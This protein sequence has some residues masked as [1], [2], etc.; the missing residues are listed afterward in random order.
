MMG[1]GRILVACMF[2]SAIPVGAVAAPQ[3]LK[4]SPDQ[5]VK[6]CAKRVVPPARPA[7]VCTENIQVSGGAP[8]PRYTFEVREGTTLPR[9]L[10]LI[11]ATGVVTATNKNPPLP[12][13]GTKLLRITVSDGVRSA[14]GSVTLQ[15]DTAADCSCPALSAGF[16]NP[17]NARGNQ[18][19][20]FALPVSGPP[21]SETVSPAYTW[22]INC[23]GLPSSICSLP[24]GMV[25]D[26]TSGVLR[27]S[28]ASDTSGHDFVFKVKITE[29]RTESSTVS[30]GAFILHVD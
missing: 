25:L 1:L 13:A 10:K 22:S 6:A 19:Y 16:G 3:P 17:P 5:V 24:P 11:A 7:A 28:P 14:N 30:P 27:G 18:P 20:G 2:V 21:S 9:G 4:I 12:A 26:K 29:K 15:M 23:T 8:Q